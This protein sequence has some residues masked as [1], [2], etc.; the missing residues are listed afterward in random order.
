MAASRG[1]DGRA[2]G[3]EQSA[4]TGRHQ[5]R[6]PGRRRLYLGR[7]GEEA[8]LRHV[9]ALGFR[10][11][12]RNYRCRM[13]EVDLIAADG[14]VLCFI[15]VKARRTGA[16][17]R[18]LEAVAGRKQSQVRRVAAYYL[19]RFG[20]T[21]PACRFDAAEVWLD[22]EGKPEKVCYVKNAF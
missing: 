1:R 10:I 3:R 19:G 7:A 11:V 8:A 6:Q 4:G 13:G 2:R 14:D 9:E 18:G 15:E 12:K 17:G 20:T 16:F 5:T 21:P 22:P